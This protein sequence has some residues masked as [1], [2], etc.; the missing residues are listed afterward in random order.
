MFVDLG[1]ILFGIFTVVVFLFLFWVYTNVEKVILG[2]FS[3]KNSLWSSKLL[4]D[5]DTETLDCR[6]L[7]TAGQLVLKFHTTDH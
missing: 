7:Y 2:L 3:F 1:D 6:S 4:E 5:A